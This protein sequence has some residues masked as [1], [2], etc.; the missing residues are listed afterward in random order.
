[1]QIDVTPGVWVEGDAV[2]LEQI[3]SNLVTNAIKYTARG[4]VVVRLEKE[5]T[6]AVLRVSDTGAG[7][8]P[9]LLP[10]LFDLF[11]Q[12]DRSL[13]RSEGGLGVGLTIVKQLVDLHGGTIEVESAGV[14]QGSTFRVQ[15]PLVDARIDDV[16]TAP[17]SEQNGDRRLRILV[18]EDNPDIAEMTALTLQLWNYRTSLASEGETA[19]EVARTQRPHVVLLDIGLPG[20]DGYQVAEQLRAEF[21][22]QE[23]KLVSLTGYAQESDAKR[24][25]QA[26][27]DRHLAKPV[28]FAALKEL[29]SSY[30]AELLTPS[31]S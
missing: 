27:F 6:H 23:M 19:I 3:V 1:M 11:S 16:E 20:L 22:S 29:L 14:D 21:S 13:A 2:R 15:L 9:E 12:A 25:L 28:N 8:E 31:A 26:G 10:R 30:E 4:S 18:V 17:E 7:I 24:A 5:P